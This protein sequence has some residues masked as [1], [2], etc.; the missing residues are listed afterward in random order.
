MYYESVLGLCG[1][2]PGPIRS[3]ESPCRCRQLL[4]AAP[5]LSRSSSTQLTTKLNRSKTFKYT[6]NYREAANN[7]A[8]SPVLTS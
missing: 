1:R 2:V 8:I 3:V 7:D 6:F 4:Q 5:Q